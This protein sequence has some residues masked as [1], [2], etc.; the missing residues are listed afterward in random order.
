MKRI[1]LRLALILA[2]ASLPGASLAAA[3]LALPPCSKFPSGKKHVYPWTAT[4]AGGVM[5]APLPSNDHSY[6]YFDF[7]AAE[8]AVKTYASA[9]KFSVV[10]PPGVAQWKSD[11][12]LF[13]YGKA[14]QANGRY[15]FTG[16]YAGGSGSDS[17]EVHRRDTLE[18]V[19]SGEYCLDSSG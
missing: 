18:I 11:Y 17:A 9:E 1:Y 6:Y 12:Q 3:K 8:D 5:S 7:V 13:L 15:Y 14:E 19:R 4:L 2:A 10:V 16:V